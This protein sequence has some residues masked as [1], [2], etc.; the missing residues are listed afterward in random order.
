MRVE[1]SVTTVS[2]IPSEAVT[3]PVL[4]GTFESGF[5]SY[6]DPPPD[7]IDDLEAWRDAGRFRFANRLSAWVE[8][9]DGLIVDAGYA[10]GGMMGST[11]VHLAKLRATF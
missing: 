4:K 6:D 11:T 3:G 5:T 2:W 9:E 10:G 8:I 1:S 7:A